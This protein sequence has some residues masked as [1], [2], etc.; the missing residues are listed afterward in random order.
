MEELTARPE[1]CKNCG[2][3]L[4]AGQRFCRFCGRPT[5]FC[6]EGEMPTRK[7]DQQSTTT[8]PAY[9]PATN[10]ISPPP[11]APQ[12]GTHRSWI[13]VFI[14]IGLFGAVV[15]TIFV[16][17]LV[18][19][20]K[21]HQISKIFPPAASNQPVV[22]Q[23]GES[24]LNEEGA[25]TSDA[26]T[27]IT[28]TFPLNSGAIF[29]LK[30]ISGSIKVEGWDKPQAE[31]KVIKRGGSEKDRRLVQ[32][33]IANDTNKLALRS[34]PSRTDSVKVNYEVKLP[35]DVGQVRIESL[36]ST[37][38]LWRIGGEIVVDLK[39]GSVELSDLAGSAKVNTAA[40]NITAVFASAALDR[41]ME[42][43]TAAGNIEVRLGP[44]INADVQ[45]ETLFGEIEDD[46]GLNLESR[47]VSQRAVGQIGSGGQPLILSTKMGKIKIKKEGDHNGNRGNSVF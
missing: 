14:A 12:P 32:V 42:L 18:F 1:Q 4:F 15:L 16:L 5:E 43:T 20:R 33:L 7:M 6:A 34:T 30:N 11:H 26:E 38:K 39:A 3:A 25:S 19:L 9:S 40:G 36:S 17:A 8:A 13:V 10:L 23:P 21:E 28:K 37:I 24:M 47:M 45:A 22:A 35:R 46:F 2:A 44:G 41:P 29:A 31:V 27:I